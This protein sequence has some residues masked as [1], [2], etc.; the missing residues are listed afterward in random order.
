MNIGACRKTTT[1]VMCPS[2]IATKVEDH[3]TRGRANALVKALSAPDPK[4]ALADDR[5]HEVLDLCVMCKACKSECPLSVDITSLKSEALAAKHEVTGVPLRSRVF[6]SIR[7]LNRLGSATAPLSN[8]PGR[9]TPLRRVLARAVGIAPERPL[10]VFHRVNLVRWFSRRPL[11]PAAAPAGEVTFLADSFTSF[12]EP[13]IGRAA[14]E[15]LEAAGYRVRLESAGCCGRADISKGLLDDARRKARR[16]ARSIAER[17]Q[18]GSP[19]VGCEPSCILTLREEHVSLLPRDPA[20]RDVAGRVKLVEELLNEAIDAGRLRLREEPS[21]AGHRI[22]FHGHCHQKAEVGTTATVGLMRRIPGVT[23]EEVDA[24]CCGMAGSFGFEAEHYEVSM[25][26]GEDR[27]F[28][29]V[30]AEPAETII[31]ATV[32][33]ADSR[34]RTARS[35]RRCTRW[36]WPGGRWR[37]SG[38]GR[39]RTRDGVGSAPRLPHPRVEAEPVAPHLDLGGGEARGLQSSGQPVRVDRRPHVTLVEAHVPLE[40]GAAVEVLAAH[41][42]QPL[43]SKPAA[44]TAASQTASSWSPVPPLA[45]SAPSSVPLR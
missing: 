10:P 14:I 5:L 7:G 32:S 4:A 15:L 45:P 17:S 1:G 20:V 19:V 30:R 41:L 2:Y 36:N 16:L 43:V 44:T 39:G 18:P 3:A 21:L 28:A 11:A 35:G 26:I 9:V 38:A 29:A 13:G 25:T 8:L 40:A 31:A 24:G 12:S 34:S 23:V 22:L 33:P 6:G 42:R 27:L 37:S